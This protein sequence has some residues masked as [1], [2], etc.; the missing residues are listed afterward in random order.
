MEWTGRSYESSEVRRFA[1]KI[2]NGLDYWR[3]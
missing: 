2:R 1:G 3:A